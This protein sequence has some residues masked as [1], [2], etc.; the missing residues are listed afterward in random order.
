MMTTSEFEASTDKASAAKR[1]RGAGLIDEFG[2]DDDPAGKDRPTWLDY[3]GLGDAPNFSGFQ[4]RPA[5][6]R[7][8]NLI[9]STPI[10]FV[11]RMSD[12]PYV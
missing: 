4:S 11:C 12:M 7:R 8:Y 3:G 1:E 6:N 10:V 9:P 2:L 5:A